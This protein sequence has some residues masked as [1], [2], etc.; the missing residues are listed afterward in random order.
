MFSVVIKG[1]CTRYPGVHSALPLPARLRLSSNATPL[2]EIPGSFPVLL[3]PDSL[4]FPGCPS[5]SRPSSFPIPSSFGPLSP[6]SE[7]VVEEVRLT[8]GGA[9]EEGEGRVGEGERA[10]GEGE[11]D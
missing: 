9:A 7:S 5:L 2:F 10:V 6:L 8:A 4:L 3:L 11:G 1:G